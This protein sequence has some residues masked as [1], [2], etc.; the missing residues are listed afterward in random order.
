MLRAQFRVDRAGLE[1]AHVARRL[2]E[3]QRKSPGRIAAARSRLLAVQDFCCRVKVP[4]SRQLPKY[5]RA[6][7]WQ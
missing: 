1:P 4:V 5:L 6:I 2:C 3:L 7:R